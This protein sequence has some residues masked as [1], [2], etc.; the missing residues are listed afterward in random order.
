[1]YG[2]PARFSSRA[3]LGFPTPCVT[4]FQLLRI[5]TKI[6]LKILEA[7]LERT[8]GRAHGRFHTRRQDLHRSIELFLL[9][10]PPP[11]MPKVRRSRTEKHLQRIQQRLR[12]VLAL[13][14]RRRCGAA[15]EQ[16]IDCL[17][18]RAD[19]VL[20][21]E[22]YFPGHLDVLADESKIGRP[23]QNGSRTGGGLP[24]R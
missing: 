16:D 22:G 13:I 11:S 4:S 17:P 8:R 23:L 1:A 5:L 19:R 15:L 20:D 12:I 6:V 18:R 9:P 3:S 10:R 24:P 14:D 21:R 2:L 7:L